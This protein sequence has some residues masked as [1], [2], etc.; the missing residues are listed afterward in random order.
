MSNKNQIYSGKSIAEQLLGNTWVGRLLYGKP[1]TYKDGY[2]IERKD[3][4]FKESANGQLVQR[5][6]ETT[7]DAGELVATGLAFGNP[8]TASN[9]MAPLVVGS[10]SYWIGHGINDGAQKIDN[11]GEGVQN[12]VEDPSWQNVGAVAKEVPMLALDVAGSLP[13]AKTITNTAKQVTPVAINKTLIDAKILGAD[14]KLFNS[15]IP[16]KPENFYRVVWKNAIDDAKK[17]KVIRGNPHTKDG[18]YFQNTQNPQGRKVRASVNSQSTEGRYVIEGTPESAEAWIDSWRASSR[19]K[20]I[21]NKYE[22]TRYFPEDY[23]ESE[24]AFWKELYETPIKDIRQPIIENPTAIPYVERY[25]PTMLE[26]GTEAFPMTNGKFEAP[27]ENFVYYKHFPVFGWRRF[28][29]KQ[30]GTLKSQLGTK[31]LIPHKDYLGIPYKQD[32]DYNYFEAHPENMPTNP[33]EHWT[34]RNPVTG[35]LLKSEN[36]PTFNL[37]LNGEKEVGMQIYRGLNGGPYSYPK[38]QIV[39]LYL[40]KFNYGKR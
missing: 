25:G 21:K 17:S 3:S 14:G 4:D 15:R 9:A 27:A 10:Q 22:L 11:I 13:V 5:M 18:P 39:P 23:S 28:N 40:R 31:L 19:R 8:L 34:S 37:L 7:K 36:H 35:Q 16:E 29:F 24:I 32:G 1:E 2:G 20:H 12:F 26:F 38:E 33:E 30:G 6:W